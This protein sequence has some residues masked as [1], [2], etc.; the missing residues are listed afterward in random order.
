MENASK[1]LIIAGAI[2][3]AIVIISLGLVVVNNV[4]NVTDNTNLNEQEIQSFNA[5]FIAYEG[6]SVS[7]SRVN[8]LIQMV[9]STNQATYESGNDNF[10][11]I[12][13]SPANLVGTTTNGKE[14]IA[15]AFATTTSS[16]QKNI[17]VGYS[18]PA[19]ITSLKSQ[20][21][22][23]K[24]NQIKDGSGSSTSD[25]MTSVATG[26]NYKVTMEY[27]TNGLIGGIIVE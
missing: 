14:F 6:E 25:A 21:A 1:A 15:L 9:I 2:L 12:I 17:G 11:A 16:K 4:R 26:K 22:I 3:L 23:K 8:S 18:D 7:A 13:Y 5:K 24:A 19:T 27:R 20:T 10:I